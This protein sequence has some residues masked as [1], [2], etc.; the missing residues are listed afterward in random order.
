VGI[1]TEITY[2]IGFDSN[3]S[4]HRVQGLSL[5]DVLPPE[6]TFVA[7]DG[8]GVYGAYD[9]DKHIYTWSYPSL[10]P[11]SAAR[12]TI[13]VNVREETTPGT[14]V[15][16]SVTIDSNDA[17]PQTARVTAVAVQAKP[18]PLQL[19]KTVTGGVQGM[20][21]QGTMYVAAGQE[22]QG[23]R[24]QGHSS[25]GQ[26]RGGRG[27][28]SARGEVRLRR[29]RRRLRSVRPRQPHLYVAR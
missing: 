23:V 24:A 29:R 3:G 15:E 18:K 10:L 21:D 16:N 12:V 22:A 6:V 25:S 11:D 5:V 7:A 14:V 17:D 9:R 27:H 8:D 19:T 20:D 2:E 1:G 13:T 26:Q 4:S 28:P